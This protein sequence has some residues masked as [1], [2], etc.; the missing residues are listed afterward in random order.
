MFNVNEV[1]KQFPQLNVAPKGKALIYLDSAA[2]TLKP[3]QVI[4]RLTSFYSNEVSNVH[5]GAHYFSDKATTEYEGARE[6]V[7]KFLN[8]KSANEI[9]FTKGTTESLNLVAMSYARHFLKAGDEVLLTQMEHH[10]NIVPWQLAAKEAGFSIQVVNVTASG[11]IDL[12]DFAGKLSQKTKLASMVYVSNALGTINTLR[13]MIQ[14]C[15]KVGAVTVVDAAQ[16]VSALQVNVQ[17]LDCDFLAFSGHKL[18]APHGIGV[19]YGRKELLDSMPP[20]QGGGSMIAKVTFGDSTF[21][22][23]PQRFEAGTPPIAEAVSLGT[24]IQFLWQLGF[25]NIIAHKKMLLLKATEALKSIPGLQIIGDNSHKTAIISFLLKD[26]HPSDVGQILDQQGLAVRTGH[27]CNQPL[28]DFYKI[29]GTVRASFSIYNSE[30]D[31]VALRASILKAK[32][33]LT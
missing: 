5:R 22:E 4:E 21:L 33:M 17:E 23:S 3:L 10:S 29:T 28:M 1:R 14:Q 9:I 19:L 15:R 8:A 24:A 20:Y 2:T 18:F 6:I 30:E 13:E 31:I 27:H 25:E 11:E 7:K 26:C 12:T 16:A 32:E